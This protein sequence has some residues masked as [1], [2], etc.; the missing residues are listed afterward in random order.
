VLHL[1]QER[2]IAVGADPTGVAASPTRN[3]VY[4]VNRGRAGSNGS[5]TVIDAETNRVAA[6]IPVQR[7]PYFIDVDA[8]GNRGY[9]ANSGS[10][11]VSVL[12]LAQR[13][14]IAVIGVGEAPGLARISPDGD[15][16]VVTNRQSGSVSIVDP[17]TDKVRSVWGGCPQATDA[18]ILPDSS[19]AFVACSGSHQVMAIG[20]AQHPS[21]QHPE[22]LN[23]PDRELA[24]LDVGQTPVHLAL[25]PDGGEIFVSNF[26]S[27]TISEIA[28]GDN[29][30]GGAYLVGAHPSGGVVSADNSTLWVSN[31]NANTIGVYSIEDGKLIHTVHVGDGPDQLAFSADGFLLFAVDARSGD[32]SVVR[33]LA[34]TLQGVPVAGELFTMLPAG[35]QPN[36]IAIKTFLVK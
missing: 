25:K 16:L 7:A 13:R 4:V 23:L 3:E 19:K 29:E 30:V 11:S 1:R 28:T 2:V 31:F 27:D 5:V 36:A 32:V 20:L 21:P 34:Y 22:R 6:T 18:V 8:A 35:D 14:Q 17:H 24:L 12:D 15:S 26:N 9:V 10:N 33:T